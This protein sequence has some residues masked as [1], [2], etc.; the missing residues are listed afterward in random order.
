MIEF[1]D[2]SYRVI[3]TKIDAVDARRILASHLADAAGV[4]LEQF[5]MKV[6]MQSNGQ[7]LSNVLI[8]LE[9]R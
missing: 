4:D 3:K 1:E 9:S 8:E 6:T 5:I 7:P 2:K